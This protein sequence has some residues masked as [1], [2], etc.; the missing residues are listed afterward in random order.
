MRWI[1][2]LIVGVVFL[3]TLHHFWPDPPYIGL[4]A[5][6]GYSCAAMRWGWWKD[7]DDHSGLR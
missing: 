7:S 1:I 3:S 6:W 5:G 2:L 4:A